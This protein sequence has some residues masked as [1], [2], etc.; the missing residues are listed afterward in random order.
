MANKRKNEDI[1]VSFIGG[2]SFDVTG[3]MT[4]IE[5]KNDLGKKHKIL[6]DCGIFQSNNIFKDYLLN[7]QNFRFKAT[8]IT[9]A[10]CEHLNGDHLLN[11]PKLYRSNCDA[12]LIVPK[13]SY[14]IINELFKDSLKI[15]N[16]TLELLNKQGKK[17]KPIFE[18]EDLDSTLEHIREFEINEIHKID[19]SLSFRFTPSGHIFNA[20]QLELFITINN[21]TKTILATGDLGN[22]TFGKKPFTEEFKPV[23]KCDM[24]IVE[25]TYAMKTDRLN[26]KMRDKDLEKIKT[27]VFDIVDNEKGKLVFA[28]FSFDRTQFLLSILYDLFK[29]DEKFNISIIL[30]SPLA[31]RLTKCFINELVGEEKE[32]L[33]NIMSWDKLKVIDSVDSSKL[34]VEDS[35]SAVVI[36]ASGFMMGG[37]ILK[38][39]PK[40]LEDENSIICFMGYS[41]PDS[42]AG[43][44]KTKKYKT[45]LIEGLE[46]K[47]KCKVIE[48]RTFSSHM[49]HYDMLKYYSSFSSID[50]I[51]LVHG[52]FDNK[53]KFADLLDE[54]YKKRCMSTK[55]YAISK[56]DVVYL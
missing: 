40:V 33:E 56:D 6:I 4:L 25:T 3:S 23:V 43:R 41:S 37:R 1:K 7:S 18:A 24:A 53:V 27:A 50:K 32:Y 11:F 55:V 54:E 19:D 26:K 47:N 21:H 52:D 14:G 30:D 39:L 13:G 49:T 35:S 28:T 51:C 34:S 45:I 29:D 46:Y 44:I 8:E 31:T 10:F 42:L 9:Y 16:K 12:D 15:N 48:L 22:I 36:S 17:V 5:F 2:N 38:Y 20:T